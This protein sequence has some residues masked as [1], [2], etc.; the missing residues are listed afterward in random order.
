VKP[1]AGRLHS[2][3]RGFT[4]V[5]LVFVVILIGILAAVT[6]VKLGSYN[7][8]DLHVAAERLRSD[9][10]KA[11]LL[12][13]SNAAKVRL[14]GGSSGYRVEQESC[15]ADATCSWQTLTNPSTAQPFEVVLPGGTQLSI[16]SFYFNTW[17]IPTVSGGS[18]ASSLQAFSLSRGAETVTVNVRPITGSS[19]VV[20]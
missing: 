17:G 18:S 4:L 12:A 9:L 14:F 10:A 2:L 8:F 13:V 20:R 5:E 16:S 6:T 7:A 1:P 15:T 19:F 11:Q 3:A